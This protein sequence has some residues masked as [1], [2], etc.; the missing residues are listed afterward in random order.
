MREALFRLTRADASDNAGGGEVEKSAASGT[1]CRF[2]AVFPNFERYHI[3]G[4]F[5]M[6]RRLLIDS[7]ETTKTTPSGA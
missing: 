1:N 2:N 7:R 3:I 4:F 6:A 5:L